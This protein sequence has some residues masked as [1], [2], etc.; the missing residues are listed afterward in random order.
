LAKS[1]TGGVVA[2]LLA[3]PGLQI[4]GARMLKPSPQLTEDFRKE[5]ERA[6]G[7]VK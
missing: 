3:T 4:V 1:L 2:R 7:E 6:A 5:V